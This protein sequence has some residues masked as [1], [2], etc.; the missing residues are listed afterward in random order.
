[1]LSSATSR[2]RVGDGSRRVVLHTDSVLKTYPLKSTVL[3]RTVGR[4]EA[5]RGVNVD[6][7]AGETV[8]LVGESGS[9]KTTLARCILGLE[10]VDSGEIRLGPSDEPVLRQ[11]RKAVAKV[12]QVVFQDPVTSL[13]PRMRIGDIV[14]EPLLVHRVADAPERRR[15]V[16]AALHSVGIPAGWMRRL[17]HQLSGGER[18]RV[19]IARALVLQPEL[20]VLDEPVSALDV[21]IQAQVLVMLQNLQEELGI[22]YLLISHDLG[23]VRSLAHDV[24]VIYQGSIVEHGP[25]DKVLNAP[26]H[27]YTKALLEA[28]PSHP[29]WNI[30]KFEGRSGSRLQGEPETGCRY[31]P[32]CPSAEKDCLDREPE[33]I[34]D[35]AKVPVACYH[36]NH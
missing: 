10:D 21:S 20:I 1:M 35:G 6:I 3:R 4:V 24:Y 31:A 17:P 18:Q 28:E 2:Q 23:V 12:V 5:L 32:R 25:P 27:P 34:G 15:R 29:S 7:H 36:P 16:V 22:S 11:D 26:R 30:E 8:A 9:G 33:L 14:G 13:S 19:A